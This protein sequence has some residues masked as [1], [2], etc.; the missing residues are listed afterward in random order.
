MTR[1]SNNHI[2]KNNFISLYLSARENIFIKEN[3]Y[4]GFAG[5]GLKLL[6]EEKVLSKIT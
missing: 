1:T 2:D 4:N 3:I 5:A 6:N